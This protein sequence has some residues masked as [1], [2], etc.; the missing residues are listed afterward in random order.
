M[1]Y[2]NLLEKY[3][4]KYHAIYPWLYVDNTERIQGWKLHLSTI[5]SEAQSLFDKILPLLKEKEVPFKIIQS[6]LTLEGLNEGNFG[7][8]QVGKCVTIYSEND[9]D[10]RKICDQLLDLTK[11]FHG[12]KINTDLRL[13]NIVYARYGGFNP[14]IE[15]NRLGEARRYIY[16]N[17]KISP[18]F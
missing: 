7:I 9:I 17:K 8:T 5:V 13:G 6:R 1:S 4:L 2:S 12:P 16:N 15:R 18:L 10:S 11:G 3:G 14:I